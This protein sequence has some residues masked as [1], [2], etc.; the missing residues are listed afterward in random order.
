VSLQCSLR[1]IA[2]FTESDRGKERRQ[3]ADEGKR[4]QER[5]GEWNGMVF[6]KM[7]DPSMNLVY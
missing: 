7:L 1:T 3:G 4:K 5:G 2:R 6:E